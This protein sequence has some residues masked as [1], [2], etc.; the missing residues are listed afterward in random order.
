MPFKG[1]KA[2]E[3]CKKK[4]TIANKNRYVKF[5]NLKQQIA[6][7][8][9]GNKHGFKKGQIK[10]KKAYS[11]PKGNKV[12]LGKK[13][14]EQHKQRLRVAF[15]G[16]KSH[17]W[18]GGISFAPYSIDW[19]ET[20]RR[21][22]RERD[23]YICQLCGKPQGDIAHD[24]H[25]IDYNK[26]NCSPTNLITLC[27]SC[28]SKVNCNRPNWTKFFMKKIIMLL[29]F[30]II[31]PSICF[32]GTLVTSGD[33]T[34]S[35]GDFLRI[36]DSSDDEWME[37]T[38]VDG[39]TYTVTRD[40]A[41]DYTSNDNPV[42]KKGT[43]VTNYRASGD[44]GIFLTSS[45]TNSPHI[46]VLTHA[47]SPW[48]TTTTRMRI[49]N[50]NGFL[51]AGSD[52]YGIYIGEADKYLKYDPTNGLQIKG[53]ITITGG[54]AQTFVQSDIPTSLATGDSWQDTDDNKLYVAQSVGADAI[55]EGEWEEIAAGDD[56]WMDWQM[57]GHTT[58]I[59]GGDIYTDTVTATQISV[60]QLDAITVNTGTLTV[61]EYIN[62]GS[63]VSIDGANEVFKVFSDTI[64]I[65]TGVNDKLDWIEDA[66][67]EVATV[68]ASTTYTPATLAAHIQVIMRAQG[69]ADTTVTYSSTTK[70]ITI[71]NATL[72]TL[73]LKWSTGTNTAT[74]CGRALGFDV[75]ADD[76]GALTYAADYQAALRV[77][78]GKL[79]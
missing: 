64:T 5:P 60:A 23:N 4:H 65:A 41:E 33:E 46:D 19:T 28:N 76:S 68:T 25:H 11:F 40:M 59:D 38:A 7:K 36:K 56:G 16:A 63:Y 54:T 14:T 12:R 62:V 39:N 13:T 37:V 53:T 29:L 52:L 32:G 22:I 15:A 55:T 47:G 18:K 71:A 57:S 2:T 77:E 79:S 24:V 8:L 78:L 21:S 17:F 50:V 20:L 26:K 72:S 75:T 66:S 67:T 49:G 1:Y 43:C 35:V 9:K 48:D 45:D 73:T 51:G 69:D 6:D 31:V 61:D 42:W 70:K 10:N 44:G 30:I 3:E 58:Y 27:H 34:F 74:T